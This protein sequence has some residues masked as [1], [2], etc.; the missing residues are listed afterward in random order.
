MNSEQ[1]KFSRLLKTISMLKEPHGRS[2]KSMAEELEVDERTIYRYIKLFEKNGFPIDKSLKDERWF[3]V[4]E[5]NDDNLLNFNI[6]EASLIRDLV[7]NGVGD[8]NPLKNGILHKLYINSELEPLA[9][10]I[11]HVRMNGI[12]NN[13]KRAIKKELRVVLRNYHSVN[14]NIIRDYYIEPY[15]LS[16]NYMVVEAYDINAGICKQFR[17]CRIGHVFVM[18]KSQTNMK[19]HEP[20]QKDAFGYAGKDKIDIVLKLNNAAMIKLR[21]LHPPAYEKLIQNSQGYFFAGVIYHPEGAGR[22][23]LSQLCNVVIEEGDELR[24]YVNEKISAY[25]NPVTKPAMVEDMAAVPADTIPL[26]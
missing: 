12:V 2:I 3:I 14:G 11:I 1:A 4:S 5:N 15:N 20:L 6:D 19:R 17:I 13:I 26:F 21:E 24:S 23:V 10:N 16:S 7:V 25:Q 8:E 9:D 18:D 22:F